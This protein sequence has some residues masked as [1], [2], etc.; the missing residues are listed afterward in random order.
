LDSDSRVW[1]PIRLGN[2]ILEHR[3]AMAPLTRMRAIGGVPNDS[4]VEYY[5]QR[6]TKGGLIVSEATFISREAGGY[7]NAPGIYTQEQVEAWRKV[8]DAVHEKG[9]VIYCQL[10]AIG[11]ANNGEID[12]VKIVS[13]GTIVGSNGKVP[14][15]MSINDIHRYLESYKNA[16]LNAIEAGFDGVEV[17]GAHGYLLEQFL[18][19]AINATRNDEYSGSLEN[20]SRFMLEAL[21][22]VC[23]AVGQERSAI[24][25]SPFLND[26]KLDPFEYWGY[27]VE[28]IRERFP[29]LAYLSCTDPRL[30]DSGEKSF[31]S[32]LLPR[33]FTWI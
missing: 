23:K 18:R 13:S 27:V 15:Q 2:Q 29:H 4:T 5:K 6:S 19:P 24:R 10:W 21:E 17:H 12:D 7:P 28:Q 20:C 31:S 3:I 8:T 33:N 25:I 22:T 16:A 11:R 26:E 30:N 32:K 14:E 1:K 9:G